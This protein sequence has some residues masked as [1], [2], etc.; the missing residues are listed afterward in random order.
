MSHTCRV[1]N[2]AYKS[3]S[4]LILFSSN[5]FL[6]SSSSFSLP[7]PPPPYFYPISIK[8]ERIT[9]VDHETHYYLTNNL[10]PMIIF[11]EQII[12]IPGRETS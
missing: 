12:K 9:S 1:D 2:S 10:L 7:P 5:F 3:I 4:Y 8:D 6:L 11:S